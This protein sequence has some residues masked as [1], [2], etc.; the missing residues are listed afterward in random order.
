MKTSAIIK[1]VANSF[2]AAVLIFVLIFCINTG[3]IGSLF[4][5]ISTEKYDSYTVYEGSVKEFNDNIT[6]IDIEWTAGN[7][8]LSKGV[9]DKISVSEKSEKNLDNDEI[10]LYKVEGS[11]LKIRFCKKIFGLSFDVASATLSKDLYIT[12]PEKVYEA[13]D[14]ETVSANIELN[15]INSESMDIVTVSGIINGVNVTASDAAI[16]TVSGNCNVSASS[17]GEL[18]ASSVSSEMFIDADIEAYGDFESVSGNIT[19][20]FDEGSSFTAEVESVSGNFNSDFQL[21]KTNDT[22][23]CGNGSIELSFESVSGNVNIEKR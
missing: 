2:T 8:Y 23:T 21:S 7:I 18:D 9:D 15:N 22:Y 12:V 3:S 16:E 6:M 19:L 5:K 13:I 10:M 20:I 1:L 17:F 14:I 11:E 4:S